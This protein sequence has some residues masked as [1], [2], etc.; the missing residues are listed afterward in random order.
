[1][2]AQFGQQYEIIL[3]LNKGRK[4]F[5]GKRLSDVWYFDRISFQHQ[6]HPNEKPIRLLEQCI[7]KHSNESD[8]ILDPFMGSGSTGIACLDTGRRFIGI[9]KD[10][11]YFEIAKQRIQK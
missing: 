3:L 5:N 6:H 9:E 10:I 1:M 4:Y 7:L 2:K 8:I 11:K